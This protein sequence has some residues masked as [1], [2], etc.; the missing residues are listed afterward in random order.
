VEGL[1]ERISTILE[2]IQGT[3][4]QRARDFM[5]LRTRRVDSVDEF[6]AALAEQRGMLLAH[7]CG[8][9]ECE[10]RI[11][12]TKATIR[13]VPLVDHHGGGGTC[14]VCGTK[15]PQRVVVAKAY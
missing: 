9:A 6:K 3:L 5:A 2:D 8:D 11:K 7:W 1:R 15:S 4:L 14:M 10:G 12:E 13:C